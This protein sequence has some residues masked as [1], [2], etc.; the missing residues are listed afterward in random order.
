MQP[1]P[2]AKGLSSKAASG[3]RIKCHHEGDTTPLGYA[4]GSCK[5]AQASAGY[6][7]KVI[8]MSTPLGKK[9]EL[10]QYPMEQFWFYKLVNRHRLSKSLRSE[11]SCA[12]S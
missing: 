5:Q 6:K 3:K 4:S 9:P 7:S 12:E 11:Q 2:A 10:F 8:K 1:H